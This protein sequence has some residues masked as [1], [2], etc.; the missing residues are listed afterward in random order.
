[1][2]KF[3]LKKNKKTFLQNVEYNDVD[4]FS[5][6]G[7]KTWCKCVKIYDGD[8][9]TVVFYYNKQPHKF[10]IRL[11]NIDTAELRTDNPI[12]MHVAKVAR[13]SLINIIDDNLIYIECLEFDKYGRLLANLYSDKKMYKSFNDMLIEK[14]LAYK[15]EGKTKLK[16]EEWYK[17]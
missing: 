4:F 12:E 11:A 16:F 5:L 10:R 14:G 17:N 2:P 3:F 13:D 6:K 9:I 15:Y 7:Y 1:M 8:T